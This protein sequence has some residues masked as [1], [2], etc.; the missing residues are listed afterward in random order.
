ME[1]NKLLVQSEPPGDGSPKPLALP[2]SPHFGCPS[3]GSARS[4]FGQV[5]VNRTEARTVMVRR[6]ST[7]VITSGPA[8]RRSIDGRTLDHSQFLSNVQRVRGASLPIKYVV[9]RCEVDQFAHVTPA[10]CGRS[11]SPDPT[12]CRVRPSM[13][14]S[15]TEP[16]CLRMPTGLYVRWV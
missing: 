16:T 3:T 2:R 12:A 7:K 4:S 10:R 8:F 1:I 5:F 15:C 11:A 6:R 14:V 9:L 13:L